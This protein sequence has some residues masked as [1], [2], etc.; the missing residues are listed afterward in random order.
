MMLTWKTPEI[1]VIKISE[2]VLNI[3]AH[4]D[5]IP[6]GELYSHDNVCQV[7]DISGAICDSSDSGSETGSDPGCKTVFAE[8]IEVGPLF[9]CIESFHCSSI[10]F[11]VK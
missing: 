9:G 4:A 2:L 10:F 3:K 6:C 7:H 11:L 5:S 8:C 1:K